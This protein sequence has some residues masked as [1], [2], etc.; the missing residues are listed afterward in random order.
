MNHH[1][2]RRFIHMGAASAAWLCSNG[3]RDVTLR[4]TMVIQIG[5][6]G[7]VMA[8]CNATTGLNP[9]TTAVIDVEDDQTVVPQVGEEDVQPV[10]PP[11]LVYSWDTE[12][13]A[14]LSPPIEVR[15]LARDDCQADGYEVATVGT[16]ALDG[17]I[18]TA[19]FICRGDF[20]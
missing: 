9:Q 19:T 17:N 11:S 16:L 18:A 1:N 20:E 10:A 3:G 2:M 5:L 12:F 7:I 14:F 4:I 8:A 15:R 13:S 6:V